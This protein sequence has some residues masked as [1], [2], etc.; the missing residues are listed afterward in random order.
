MAEDLTNNGLEFVLNQIKNPIER[1]EALCDLARKGVHIP[2]EIAFQYVVY[3]LFIPKHCHDPRGL[4]LLSAKN[5]A[6][7]TGL[8]EIAEWLARKVAYDDKFTSEQRYLD[9]R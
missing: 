1:A 8:T 7:D 2:R 3:A 5:F 4:N 9:A 6:R